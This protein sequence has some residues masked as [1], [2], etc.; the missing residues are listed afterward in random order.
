MSCLTE[1]GVLAFVRRAQDKH[2]RR[3]AEAHMA[4]C[5]DCRRLVSYVARLQ[6]PGGAAQAGG[7]WRWALVAALIVAVVGLVL[8]LAR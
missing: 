3:R 7:L 6:L 1:S 2:E 5:D 4:H 8:A